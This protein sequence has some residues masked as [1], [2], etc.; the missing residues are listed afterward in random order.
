MTFFPRNPLSLGLTSAFDLSSISQTNSH[1]H[2]FSRLCN[3][4]NITFQAQVI[5]FPPY[6]EEVPYGFSGLELQR[7]NVGACAFE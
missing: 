3:T 1:N 4:R 5:S 2:D 6:W 7:L